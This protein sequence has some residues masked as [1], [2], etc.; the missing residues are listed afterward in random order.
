MVFQVFYDGENCGVEF[1]VGWV[2]VGWVMV[3]E[4]EYFVFQMSYLVVNLGCVDLGKVRVV[5]FVI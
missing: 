2:Y 1:E 4:I 3:D 5:L